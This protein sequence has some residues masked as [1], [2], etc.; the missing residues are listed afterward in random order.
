MIEIRGLVKTY[1]T[2]LFMRESRALDGL[3]LSVRGGE[4]FGFLGPNGA[5][6]TTTIKILLGFV[7]ATA[8]TATVLGRSPDDPTVRARLGYLPEQPYFYDYLTAE[9][10]L[11]YVGQLH[12]L[13][14]PVRRARGAALLEQLEIAH[15]ARIPL[16]KFSKGMLQRVG[17]AQALLNEPELVI[18]DE[19]MSGLDPMGRKLVRDLILRLRREGRT[20]F[21]SSHILS[22]VETISDRVAMVAGGRLVGQGTVDELLA[23]R[24]ERVELCAAGIAPQTASHLAALATSHVVRGD[25]HLFAID[26]RERADA[27]VAALAREGGRLVAFASHRGTLEELFVERVQGGGR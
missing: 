25:Q 2:G 27:A 5:G 24:E 1:R 26:S 17:L 13:A 14:G 21:F 15:A 8:G 23:G 9:E 20:V 7:R 6:K 18:L 10:L 4:V 12:A 16:R 3:D 19:P 22:D 11:D